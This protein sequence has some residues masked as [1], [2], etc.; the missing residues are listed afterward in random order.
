MLND[1]VNRTKWWWA[2]TKTQHWYIQTWLGNAHRLSY[3]VFDLFDLG[4]DLAHDLAHDLYL[5]VTLVSELTFLKWTSKDLAVWHTDTSC[6]E[7]A[8]DLSLTCLTY[9]WP[10][11]WSIFF[12]SNIVFLTF[13]PERNQL[14]SCYLVQWCILSMPC[15]GVLTDFPDLYLTYVVTYFPS[16][17]LCSELWMFS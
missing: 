6:P 7:F 14:G 9:I 11:L 15:L 2:S 12:S 4:H 3:A 8:W 1:T 10:L 13:I 16:V 17:T 5:S